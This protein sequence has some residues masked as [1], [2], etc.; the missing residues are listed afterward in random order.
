MAVAGRR[1]MGVGAEAEVV[2]RSIALGGAGVA[3]LPD[4]RVVFVPRTAPGDRA[5]IRVEKSKP[6]WA[7][8]SLAH[9]IDPSP[10]RCPP[11]CDLYGVCGGCHLQ[12]VPYAEQLRW[13]GRAIADVLT[14]IG[15]FERSTPPEV[16]AS[17]KTS[18]Y[19][20]R[21]SFTLRR[22]RGGRVVAGFHGLDRPAHVVDVRG[23][24]VLPGPELVER[25]LELRDGWGS[26][27]R[28]LPSGGRLRLTLRS[29]Q[30]GVDLLV[31]GGASPWDP[32]ELAAAVP[33]LRRL[34]HRPD[35]SA[36]PLPTSASEDPADGGHFVQ[37]N[38]EAATL[39]QSH[40]VEVAGS[41][42]R[43]V[44]A[45]CGSGAFG[46]A[47]V[48]RGWTVVGIERDASAVEAVAADPPP[49]LTVRRGKVEEHLPE[50][51]PVDLVVL[52][53]PRSG[54]NA[55]VTEHLLGEPPQ[56]IVYVSCDP[57]TLARDLR[58][59]KPAFE[60]SGLKAFDLF[61]Q[62]AHVETVAELTRRGTGP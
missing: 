44:D 25:W 57:S 13:K 37:V 9:L 6:R 58:L 15:G 31:E 46:R 16:V 50:L 49:G 11:Q 10:V 61:P 34:H 38:D 55:R 35:G 42:E 33:R 47:L 53:P 5:R 54:V 2:V 29:S 24:C 21:V 39:L 45:Y 8:G 26:G 19:R 36:G 43:A 60:L 27:A 56:R 52:N 1:M 20:N 40:V 59:L 62:T 22:L 7:A 3:D 12:H 14:R 28:L 41:G 18:G 51:L 4:G 48:E 23:E 32:S 30:Q 17:P